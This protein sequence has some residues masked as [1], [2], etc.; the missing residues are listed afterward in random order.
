M[1]Y[2]MSTRLEKSSKYIKMSSK[3]TKII[4][5]KHNLVNG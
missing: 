5:K 3:L 4:D 1:I 2:G